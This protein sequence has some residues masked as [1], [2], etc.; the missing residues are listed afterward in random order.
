MYGSKGKGDQKIEVDK[1]LPA[2]LHAISTHHA[3]LQR[4]WGSRYTIRASAIMVIENL[5][6]FQRRGKREEK[7]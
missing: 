5:M 6:G 3:H 1:G 2:H 7:F 4:Q